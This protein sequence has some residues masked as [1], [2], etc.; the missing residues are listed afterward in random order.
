MADFV[1]NIA[2]EQRRRVVATI[3]GSLD[4]DLG[5]H[6]P[7]DVR[8]AFRE[9][10]ISAIGAY[11]D[12]TLDALRASTSEGS[13]VNEEAIAL[14]SQLAAGQHMIVAAL[15][16]QGVELELAPLQVGTDVPAEVAG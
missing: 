7:D 4:R 8:A 9:R 1:S 12:F 11:H 2:R 10:V 14:F 3:L 13:V 15:Q 6:L 5:P 16:A